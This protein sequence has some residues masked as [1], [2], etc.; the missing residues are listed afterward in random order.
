MWIPP[1]FHK[2]LKINDD[3]DDDDDDDKGDDHDNKNMPRD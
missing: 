1:P 2:K 3:Y